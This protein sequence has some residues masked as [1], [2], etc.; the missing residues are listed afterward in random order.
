MAEEGDFT[1]I[2]TSFGDA[3]PD[4][5]RTR[6][7]DTTAVL[8]PGPSSASAT[9][10]ISTAFSSTPSFTS[11]IEFTSSTAPFVASRSPGS[12]S[13]QSSS[14]ARSTTSQSLVSATSS[15]SQPSLPTQT[16][17]GS[18]N[19]KSPSAGVI[20]GIVVASTA[21]LIIAA[22]GLF[23]L[24]HRRRARQQRKR[25]IQPPARRADYPTPDSNRK[26]LPPIVDITA[27][28]SQSF[29]GYAEE[30]TSH[31]GSNSPINLNLAASIGIS[32]DARADAYIQS[33]ETRITSLQNTMAWMVD[34]MQQLESR[35]HSERGSTFGRLM[36]LLH[37]HPSVLPT[38]AHNPASLCHRIAKDSSAFTRDEEIA[39]LY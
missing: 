29:P 4:A 6:K 30:A 15:G 37:T 32:S 14:F 10:I 13:S 1:S 17:L 22:F 21:V 16:I 34:H 20:A 8:P 25:I 28:Q 19:R 7:G 24:L 5:T 31:H 38:S 18:E 9:S 33:M 39:E 11:F 12:L 27:S 26:E 35:I 23:C 2:I 3:D 36:N